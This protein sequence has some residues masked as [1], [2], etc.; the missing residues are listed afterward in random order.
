MSAT[1]REIDGSL[2][3]EYHSSGQINLL[4]PSSSGV[5]AWKL[6]PTRK[7]LIPSDYEGVLREVMRLMSLPQ[8]EIEV[9]RISHSISLAGL[10][11]NGQQLE[12]DK[13]QHLREWLADI[14][15]CKWM[16]SYLESINK[17]MPTLYVGNAKNIAT[18]A[19]QHLSEAD[20]FGQRVSRHRYLNWSDMK[21][22][23]IEIPNAQKSALEAIEFVT[24]SLTVSAFTKRV[25]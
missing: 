13:V 20:G 16:I 8:G 9:T 7:S 12:G 17:H 14:D 19:S 25:G 10:R 2:L 1:W 22:H 11:I 24:Q 21:L 3:Q 4:L 23:W 5:Y 18:R 6:N 15:N